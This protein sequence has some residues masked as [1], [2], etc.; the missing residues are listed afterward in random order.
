MYRHEKKWKCSIE[1]KWKN[2]IEK[3]E[4]NLKKQFLHQYSASCTNIIKED[5][6]VSFMLCKNRANFAKNF[7]GNTKR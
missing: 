4:K 2:V 1:K 6:L 7:I 5:W 3:K